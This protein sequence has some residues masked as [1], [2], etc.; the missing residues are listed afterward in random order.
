M[1]LMLAFLLALP[2]FAQSGRGT[3]LGTV[4]DPTG[5]VIPQVAV[6]VTNTETN[7]KSAATSDELGNYRA[8]YLI[9]GPYAV[10]FEK[11]GFRLH[12]RDGII[13]VLDATVRVDAELAVGAVGQS[14]EVIANAS[15]LETETS[16]AGTVV[17]NV[18]VVNVPVWQRWV[19]TFAYL[20]PSVRP[21]TWQGSLGGISV[22][23]QR[24]KDTSFNF[25]GTSAQ[26]PHTNVET[27]APSIDAVA[28]FKITTEIPSAEFAHAAG[29][30]INVFI[31]NG[32]NDLHGSVFFFNR[33]KMLRALNYFDRG[34]P[35]N[36][37]FHQFG[38]TAGGPIYFPK[39]YNG[40][41]R[42]FFFASFQGTRHPYANPQVLSL[43]D[44]RWIG[45]DFSGYRQIYDPQSSTY[46]AA[47]NRWSRVPFVGNQIPASRQDPVARKI[48]PYFPAP[49][50]PPTMNP[51][52]PASNFLWNPV[53]SFDLDAVDWRLDHSF[54]DSSKI[55]L[56]ESWNYQRG[57]TW[58]LFTEPAAD[59]RQR[60]A[61]THRGSWTLGHNQ[62]LSATK[63]NE[64]RLG[65]MRRRWQSQHPSQGQNY[66]AKIGIPEKGLPNFGWAFP[67][68]N[69]DNMEALGPATGSVN[70][71]QVEENYQFTEN[72]TFVRGV[73][74]LKAGY[75][76]EHVR[77]SNYGLT[78]G[79]S[80]P[81]G[82]FNFNGGQT[83]F[84]RDTASGIPFADFLMG[85]PSSSSFG[86]MQNPW[87][88]RYWNHQ[89]YF[90]DDWKVNRRLTLNF[91]L[92]YNLDLPRTAV[93]N[94][95]SNFDP[96]AMDYIIPLP[97]SATPRKGTV[98]HSEVDGVPKRLAKIQKLNFNPRFGFAYQATSKTVLRGGIG[99]YNSQF[100]PNGLNQLFD[101]YNTGF[102]FS[103]KTGGDP[104][105][106]YRL[107]EGPLPFTYS[108]NQHGYTPYAGSIT[109]RNVSWWDRDMKMPYTI[110]W[111][112]SIQRALPGNMLLETSYVG[113]S[114]VRLIS[115]VNINQIPVEMTNETVYQDRQ[116][117]KPYIQFGNITYWGNIAHSTYHGGTWK[118]EKRFSHG[119]NFVTHFTFSKSI[120][121]ASGDGFSGRTA[122]NLA[123]ERGVSDFDTKRRYVISG[124]YQLPFGPGKF[125]GRQ[126]RGLVARLIEG[127]EV[128]TMG[129]FQSG[130]W[131]T[132]SMGFQ[133]V[134]TTHG[135]S[136]RPDL[137]PGVPVRLPNW[138][139]GADRFDF[140]NQ[141]RYYNAA[142]FKAPA[143]FTLGTAGRNI[144][145]SPPL[146]YVDF[147]IQK[148]VTL[149]ERLKLQL[150][151][152][153]ENAFNT[154]IFQAPN[155]S[156][157]S[158]TFGQITRTL[159]NWGDPL[160]AQ[161]SGKLMW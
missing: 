45:G 16:T 115:N 133:G 64:A 140:A 83:A 10:T 118:L 13:L 100:H 150:R 99:F 127:Y 58:L 11:E 23:G 153:L 32:T 22:N 87:R 142:A 96:D 46:D 106:W 119:L 160:S 77:L 114:G 126:S 92:R 36:W 125:F 26:S 111:T 12:R 109:G 120:D 149:R 68:F 79:G 113:S 98:A 35:P 30:A 103:G 66:A 69:I 15:L 88:V 65:Y 104:T 43:P 110:N 48:A 80:S 144:L 61:P 9:P 147:A 33:T 128:H 18:I 29:G 70:I 1:R 143:N 52:G 41:N 49:N 74:T 34:Q 136:T 7:V 60:F 151:V 93:G 51:W 73:H 31:K 3:I 25:D 122:Y 97:Y 14:V 157:G 155:A 67:R 8:P 129:I 6:T 135:G 123:L 37:N 4:T 94:H 86:M 2:L 161:L 71:D 121:N 20:S 154:S 42:S 59:D 55:F 24:S 82:V 76:L 72:F 28:E 81:S 139:T 146:R 102:N 40:K 131:Q 156:A 54:S 47:T 21:A 108:I 105:Y 90:Q 152:E 53:N 130:P 112:F 134:R 84:P 95:Q 91:G 159:G 158:S 101:E 44:P 117:Y 63:F 138:N 145:P 27:I 75:F 62:T 148:N 78:A 124:G 116:G 132:P 38:G 50:R 107:S 57:R 19:N 137:V 39:L 85:T 5:A 56:R 141:P 89:L 17:P